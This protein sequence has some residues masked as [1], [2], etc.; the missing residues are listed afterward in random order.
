MEGVD[1][2]DQTSSLLINKDAEMN[3]TW[4]INS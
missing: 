3:K 2:E 1:A 4:K